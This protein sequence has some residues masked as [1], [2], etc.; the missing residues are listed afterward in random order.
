MSNPAEGNPGINALARAIQGRIGANFDAHSDLVLD[1]GT[2]QA[3]GSLLTNTFPRPIPKSDYL[4]AR[5]LTLGKAGAYLTTTL[6]DGE[7][8]HDGGGHGGHVS[9]GGEH[10]HDGGEHDHVV[11]I[12]PKMQSLR[13]GDR[14]LVAWVQND[15]IVVDVVVPA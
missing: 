3:D 14:V 13:A 12:P 15:A 7:H 6:E 5:H 1:F 2:I 11:P 10:S 8:Q 4:V 9:G